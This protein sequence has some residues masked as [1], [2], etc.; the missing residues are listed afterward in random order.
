M[1]VYMKRIIDFLSDMKVAVYTFIILLVVSA[2]GTFIPQG[3]GAEMY[4]ARYPGWLASLILSFQ[5]DTVY[6]AWYFIALMAFLGVSLFTCLVRRMKNVV[7]P[8]RLP[9]GVNAADVRG[10]RLQKKYDGAVPADEAAEALSGAGYRVAVV[11]GGVVGHRRRWS[12]FGEF[13][14]HAGVLI[15]VVGGAARWFGHEGRIHLFEG[16]RYCLPDELSA[17]TIVECLDVEAERDANTGRITDFKTH[18]RVF[19][20][21][22]QPVEK[23]VEVND[24]LT[25]SRLAFYQTDMNDEGEVGLAFTGTKL[26]E[27]ETVEDITT[28][29]LAWRVAGE[30]GT[31][32]TAPDSVVELGGTGYVMHLLDYFSNFYVTEEGVTD[33]NPE[34]N[35]T[36]VWML[37]KG[38][39]RAARGFSFYNDSDMNIYQFAD[40]ALAAAEFEMVITGIPEAPAGRETYV[41]A[42]GSYVP[43]GDNRVHVYLKPDPTN[44]P[45]VRMRQLTLEDTATGRSVDVGFS[46]RAVWELSD[47]TYVV[48][49]LGKEVAAYSGLTVSR[50]PGLGIF[51][52]GAILF[53]LGVVMALY[54]R[55]EQVYVVGD[56]SGTILAGRSNKGNDMFADKFEGMAARISDR[57][58]LRLKE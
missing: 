54:L 35:P 37:V 11:S 34:S 17:E 24:A 39:E 3:L 56:A 1:P 5:F 23:I 22:K 7:A 33:T 15:I 43:L 42:S 28:V 20:P 36:A 55:H 18:L 8:Y 50:D 32:V 53:S 30:E 25:Y 29:E 9:D 38:D 51:Y 57:L 45:D 12:R 6:S 44:N 58:G 49:F 26:A 47:G 16:Y 21:G 4:E 10:W 31:T 41:L 27:G 14:V 48:R 52:A 19:E 46:E 40:P 13:F 2:V